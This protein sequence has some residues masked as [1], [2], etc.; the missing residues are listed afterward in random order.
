MRKTTIRGIDDGFSLDLGSDVGI[1]AAV[2]E[3]ANTADGLIYKATLTGGEL[4]ALIKKE[5]RAWQPPSEIKENNRY[6]I[7]AYDW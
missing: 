5:W 1:V 4:I 2:I 7:T 6:E 3:V